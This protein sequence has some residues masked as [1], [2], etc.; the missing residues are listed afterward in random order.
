MTE[1][2]EYI[3]V[4]RK[5]YISNDNEGKMI[6]K[7]VVEIQ[8]AFLVKIRDNTFNETIGENIFE[9]VNNFLEVFRPIK[10]N[11]KSLLKKFYQL[12]NDNEEME[13]EETD[14]PGIFKIK[15]NLFDYETPLCK[16][17]NDFNYLPKI[18]SDQFTFDI[19]GIKTYE[20]YELNN[21]VT[22]DLEEPWL[23]IGVP[24]QLCDHICEPYHFKNGI[25]KWPMCS[26]DINGFCNGKELPG[27][28]VNNHEVTTFARRENYGQGQYGNAKAERAYNP[29][30]DI[31]RIFD[32]NYGADNAGY[33]QNNQEYKKEHHDPSTYGVRR[34]E[35]IKYSF[36]TD[37]EYVAIKE[38]ECFEHSK[39]NIDTCANNRPPMLEKDMPRKYLELTHAEAI[40]ANCDVNATNIILQGLPPEVYA[41]VS[42]YKVAKELWEIIQLL[43]QGTSL[44]KQERE[45]KLYD[46]FDKFAYKKREILRDFYL[47]FSLLLNDMNIYNVK[48][49]QF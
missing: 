47:R 22:R 49:E 32:R 26:L 25:T 21:T 34:F 27:M 12:S 44:T 16:A 40:Q 13:A 11:M 41:L 48:L 1:L 24:C 43:M 7:F 20:E 31:N 33:T 39:T 10:I 4:T 42:N 29:Y 3:F 15:G 19:Q 14:D 17:F 45:C 36:D 9:H 46:E 28:K 6:E 37:D 35:M 18:N 23:D 30:L 38:H 8:G 2:N 5:N